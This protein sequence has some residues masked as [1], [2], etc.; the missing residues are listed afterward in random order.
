MMSKL[1]ETRV[2]GRKYWIPG[3]VN[4]CNTSATFSSREKYKNML[5][6]VTA[7]CLDASRWLSLRCVRANRCRRMLGFYSYMESNRLPGRGMPTDAPGGADQQTAAA[8]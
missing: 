4:F 7:C 1:A 3:D 5:V 6:A 8:C 2:H